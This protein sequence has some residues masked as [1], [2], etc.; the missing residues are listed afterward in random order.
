MTTA[1]DRTERGTDD[2]VLG[3]VRALL[4][5]IAARAADGEVA[6]AVPPEIVAGLREA[7]VFRMALPK[8]WG[9]EQLGLLQSAEVVREVAEADGSTGWTVQVASMAWTFLRG[10]P[11]KTLEEEVFGGGADLMLRGAVAPKGRGRRWRMATASVAGGHW[12][13]VRSPRTGCSRA[14]WSKVHRRCRMAA[15]I[16]GSR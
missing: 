9:G 2:S 10:L 14:S 13:V 4:P 1:I 6:R 8:V 12:P 7:G 11:R 16:S 15:W 5:D 3:R